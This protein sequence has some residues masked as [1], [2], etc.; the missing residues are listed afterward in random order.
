MNIPTT[1]EQI[2]GIIEVM[3]DE[4]AEV[5]VESVVQKPWGVI[6]HCTLDGVA[7]DFSEII[8]GSH[9]TG[10]FVGNEDFIDNH[11]VRIH[12][13]ALTPDEE[14]DRPAIP[15]FIMLGFHTEGENGDE[16]YTAMF[17]SEIL[18]LSPDGNRDDWL[19]AAAEIRKK[20]VRNSISDVFSLLKDILGN[21]SED[22]L[23][24]IMKRPNVRDVMRRFA[25]AA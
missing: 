19:S 11:L 13:E 4:Y 2:R 5:T 3:G 8:S 23:Q 14:E 1:A 9:T 6:A 18:I 25:A 24:G 16:D 17:S 22:E 12:S 15:E 20:M 21:V 7:S 10:F